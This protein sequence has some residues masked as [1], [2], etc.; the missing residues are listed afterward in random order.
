MFNE[1]IETGIFKKDEAEQIDSLDKVERELTIEQVADN[2]T[3]ELI[4]D[5][6][7]RKV[8]MLGK[9]MTAEAFSHTNNELICFK[10]IT[11][12]E[13]MGKNIPKPKIPMTI[14]PKSTPL[15]KR[16]CSPE[17][18]GQFLSDLISLNEINGARVPIPYAWGEY[19]LIDE[20]DQFFVKEKIL[21]LAMERI[22]GVS[23]K[24]VLEGGAD[25]P[26]KFNP[27]I[28]FKK[29]RSFLERMHEEKAIFHRDL[30]SGNI[31]IDENGDPVII[32]FGK[33]TY[34]DEGDAYQYEYTDKGKVIEGKYVSDSDF[35][36]QIE[37]KVRAELR[38]IDSLT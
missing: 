32:D 15:D 16:F 25:F 7:E 6:L 5:L 8:S 30:H 26:A 38:K 14:S 10:V 37:I 21:V 34:G 22:K 28:F 35:I 19:E 1:S 31:M 36:D 13:A 11:Q 17:K 3:V 23:I 33:S 2:Q 4:K 18:E 29:V 20:G 27:D 9:G 12:R 24:D